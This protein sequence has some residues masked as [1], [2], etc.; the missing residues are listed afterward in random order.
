M[1]EVLSKSTPMNFIVK[2][3]VALAPVATVGNSKSPIKYLGYDSFLVNHFLKHPGEY[4]DQGYL[5]ELLAELFCRGPDKY[6]CENLIFLLV[7]YD[8]V[9]MDLKRLPVYMSHLPTGTSKWNLVH[10]AQAVR[11]G[12]MQMLNLGKEG[13]LRCYGQSTAPLIPLGDISNPNIHL[14]R[15]DNDWLADPKDVQHL[16]DTLRGS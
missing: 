13:N 1:F 15:S 7:G 16:I 9:Q 12:R 14:F 4:M 10:F 8:S 3:F 5:T 2:P 11:S 6:L